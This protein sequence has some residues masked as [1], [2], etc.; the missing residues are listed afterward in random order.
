MTETTT[1]TKDG[2]VGHR[3][4]EED[5]GNNIVLQTWKEFNADNGF[6]LAAAL[7][8][9]TVL[10]LP[11]MLVVILVV[12]SFFVAAGD[13]VGAADVTGG[14]A[15]DVVSKPVEQA[16]GEQA[17]SQ[18]MTILEKA[19]DSEKS[20]LAAIV[21][22][23]V[24]LFSATTAVAQLQAGLN[25]IWEV[26]PHPKSGVVDFIVKRLLSLGM[27]I[28]LGFLIVVSVV[29]SFLIS[30]FS[31][32]VLPTSL[33]STGLSLLTNLVTAGLMTVLF[34]AMFKFLPDAKIEWRDTWIGAAVTAV[35]FVVAKFGLGF[36]LSKND[37]GA[38]YGDAGAL[39]LILVWIYYSMAILLFGAEFTQVYAR[40][41]GSG[42]VPDDD[43]VRVIQTTEH[44][45]GEDAEAIANH[46]SKSSP[47]NA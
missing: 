19:R 17:S 1:N 21:G 4:V 16:I 22:L 34:A 43:A 36:Y 7:A 2:P 15:Q 46:Q 11:P 30:A 29:V 33:S 24:L 20:G 35:L 41:H 18:L 8:Y 47:T 28:G 31:E 12:A 40:R 26:E 9:Y 42:I 32:E 37:P 44:V 39:V 10:A 14:S 27:V 5:E 45:D 23:A 38:S 6:R 25:D 3:K 13:Q